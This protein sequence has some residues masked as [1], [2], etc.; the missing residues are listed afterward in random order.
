[1]TTE[2]REPGRHAAESG[3][4][5]ATV[6]HGYDKR[7]VEDRIIEL[8]A[9][10]SALESEL[11]NA[12][13]QVLTAG[14]DPGGDQRSGDLGH[15][16]VSRRVMQILRLADE[17]AQQARDEAAQEATALLE[18]ARAE[19]RSLL[20]GAHSTAEELL[21]AAM[22]RSQEELA[23][24]RAETSRLIGSAREEAPPRVVDRD[25]P[26]VLAGGGDRTGSR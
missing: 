22:R 5:F 25:E 23:A 3:R 24:A 1:M 20:E 11:E 6:T 10:I 12:H 4:L 19:A 13:R 2:H 8:Q 15:D 26:H 7:Q 9:R 18:R 17:E 21:R 16:R 14:D